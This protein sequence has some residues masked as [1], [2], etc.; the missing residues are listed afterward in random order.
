ML[1]FVW[2][3][4]SY[5]LQVAFA[6]AFATPTQDGFTAKGVFALTFLFKHSLRGC[7]RVLF[8]AD[9]CS[10]LILESKFHSMSDDEE[11]EEDDRNLI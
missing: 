9:T 5:T 6:K 10:R 8:A 3:L 1:L 2:V 7:L 11:A 4:G